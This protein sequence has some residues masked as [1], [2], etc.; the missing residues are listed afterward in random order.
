M[1]TFPQV[2]IDGQLLGGFDEVQEASESGRLDELLRR[3]SE[4]LAR[5]GGWQPS[6]T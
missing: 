6:Q 3:L 5:G 1:M 2:L 4:R